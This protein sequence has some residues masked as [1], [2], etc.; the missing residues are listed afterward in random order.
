[1]SKP[2]SG[3]TALATRDDIKGILGEIDP[4]QMLAILALRP[5][6]ADIE[7]VSL[8][9]GG[10]ADIFE[11]GPPVKGVASDI[12]TILTEAEEEEPPRAG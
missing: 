11:P 10:D 1:M 6:I 7:Q 2:D 9:M 8:W 5:T 4:P 3:G 12:L